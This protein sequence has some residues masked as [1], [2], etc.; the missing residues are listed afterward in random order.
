[1]RKKIHILEAFSKTLK[2]KKTSASE[3][4]KNIVVSDYCRT[5]YASIF[6]LTNNALQVFFNDKMIFYLIKGETYIQQKN[7]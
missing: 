6:L 1:M 3:R 4:E 5:N 2:R 7:S